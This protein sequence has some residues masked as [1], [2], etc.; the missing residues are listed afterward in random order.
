LAPALTR[1]LVALT[2]LVSSSACF[3]GYDSRWLEAKRS[4]QRVAAQL[5]PAAI[6]TTPDEPGPARTSRRILRVR[7]RPN[8]R[9]LGQTVDPPKRNA[10][11]MTDANGVLEPTFALRLEVERVE[12]WSN[13]ADERLEPA[14]AAL[15][16]DDPGNDVDVVVGMI[17]AMPRPTDS[18]HE[19]GMAQW[20]GK[21]IVVRAASRL[22]EQDAIDRGFYE[23]SADDRRRLI[24]LREGHRALAVFLHELGHTLGAIHETDAQSLMRPTYDPKMTEFGPGAVA[25]MRAAL[26][27]SDRT[28]LVRRQLDVLR[29]S[30]ETWVPAERAGTIAHL[31]A[32]LPAGGTASTDAGDGRPAVA[33]DKANE[34]PPE[35]RGDDR[36]R[37]LRASET[38]RGGAAG[39][40]YGIAKPLFAAYPNVAAV[41]DLRCQLATVRWLDR[42][43]MKAECAPFIRLSG[44]SDAGAEGAR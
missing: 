43:E 2:T 5:A 32:M 7:V 29:A 8:K 4:Q 30:G 17:G 23:L 1:R 42:D 19:L 44:G 20:L 10:D 36:Q 40:A 38:L 25:L 21:H 18:L 37:F 22:G 26:D 15:Q 41:Q 3:V 11:L 12:P 33:E 39:P 34:A 9:Y 28:A 24:R 35:L 13:E 14:I 31:Q 27:R 6:A 16:A